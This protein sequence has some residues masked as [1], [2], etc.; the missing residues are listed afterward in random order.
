[1]MLRA[2]LVVV[3]MG[4]VAGSS[5]LVAF[6]DAGPGSNSPI[7]VSEVS[8]SPVRGPHDGRVLVAR[9]S[10]TKPERIGSTKGPQTGNRVQDAG[11]ADKNMGSSQEVASSEQP[12]ARTWANV[13]SDRIEDA[14]AVEEKRLRNESPFKYMEI[15]VSHS[16][17]TFRLLGVLPSGQT[18]ELHQCRVGLGGPGFPT[19][20]GV[21][22]VTHIYDDEPWWIPPKDRAWAAGQSPSK[23]VYGGTM[24]PLLKKRPIRFKKQ[25]PE[26]EDMIAGEVQLDDYGYRFHGTNQPRS[27]GRNQSHGCVRMIPADAKKV[28]SLI[29]Q[30]VGQADRKESANGSFVVLKGTVRLNL[31]K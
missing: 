4:L 13:P 22:Y 28:A 15:E 18:Q 2:M 3:G 12:E 27:I 30:H 16:A 20:V 31:I 24:A 21:Y 11:T 14:R 25:L 29:V 17:H 23:K 8:M 9:R 26:P 5:P 10:S 1:M 6:S 19:P 7:P